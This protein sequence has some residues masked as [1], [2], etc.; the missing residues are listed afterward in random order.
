MTCR[1]WPLFLCCI[2]TLLSAQVAY[3][4]DTISVFSR[5]SLPDYHKLN[6]SLT[7][8]ESTWLNKKKN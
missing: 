6:V 2:V 5:E 7:E 4:T 1:A 3:S 8:S